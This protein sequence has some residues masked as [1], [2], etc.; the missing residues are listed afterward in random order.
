M[1]FQLLLKA[2]TP[3]S[4]HDAGAGESGNALTFNRQKQVVL[5]DD[6]EAVDSVPESVKTFSIPSS[7]VPVF[8]QLSLVETIGALI[9]KNIIALYSTL[10]GTGLFEGMDRYHM[11]ETRMRSAANRVRSLSSFWSTVC[12]DLNL[13]IHP[14]SYDSEI[15]SLFGLPE[16]LQYR[17]IEAVLRNLRAIIATAR[18]WNAREKQMRMTDV[19]QIGFFE[20]L[21]PKDEMVEISY[22]D[23]AAEASGKLVMEVPVVSTNGLRHQLV[24]HPGWLH[25]VEH[26][27]IRG[28]L[29][30]G[31]DLPPSVEA[32]FV[33]G[34]NIYA[35]AKQ[36]ANVFKL[37]TA[38]R[39]NYPLLD[40]IGG[41]TDSFDIGESK[42][43]VASWIVCKENASAVGDLPGSDM[44]IFDMVDEVTLTRHGTEAG[45]GQMIYNF[46]VLV[47]GTTVLVRFYI[48]ENAQ[49][50]TVG[51]FGA[52]LKRYVDGF[53]VVAGQSAR[54]FGLVTA[55]WLN[56]TPKDYI[57]AYEEYLKIN[58][59]QLVAWMMDGTLGSDYR[60]LT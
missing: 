37:K 32:I 29:P 44:S 10:S 12:Q 1:N 58:R 4:H 21:D 43:A 60:V 48:R 39:K 11:L 22:E 25:L 30:G 49:P 38:I 14:G 24:R 28:D 52:A 53:P 18:L 13:P 7:M 50:L 26:L 15:V 34:G 36:P 59:D 19:E 2:E 35:G 56:D 8:K 6:I 5:R 33:N 46:E 47:P 42:L 16:S 23:V 17:V 54:G 31:G 51:A 9:T 57:D 55:E 20:A 27:G 41:V 40:L 45:I 3:I